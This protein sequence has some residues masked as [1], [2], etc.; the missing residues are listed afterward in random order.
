MDKKKWRRVKERCCGHTASVPIEHPHGG[1]YWSSFLLRPGWSPCKQSEVRGSWA[2]CHIAPLAMWGEGWLCK[3]G[4]S[5]S[6][7]TWGEP[8]LTS[9]PWSYRRRHCWPIS[10]LLVPYLVW[11]AHNHQPQQWPLSTICWEL[12]PLSACLGGLEL[13]LWLSRQVSLV[14]NS[15]S[16]LFLW[17]QPA[18]G[19]SM[20]FLFSFLKTKSQQYRLVWLPKPEI[21]NL[22]HAFTSV[23]PSVWHQGAFRLVSAHFG[24]ALAHL[25]GRLVVPA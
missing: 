19:V 4:E 5:P 23:L 13:C 9:S 11:Q 15:L 7:L 22:M 1:A 6:P 20:G 2:I 14:W 16:R 24:I 18:C 21:T 8:E 25:V 10:F 12:W 17:V 3:E